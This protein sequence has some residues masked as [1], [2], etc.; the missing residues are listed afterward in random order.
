M[1]DTR[2]HSKSLFIVDGKGHGIESFNVVKN[3]DGTFQFGDRAF[4]SLNALPGVQERKQTYVYVAPVE[5]R[6]M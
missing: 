3:Q 2:L 6:T 1:K 5:L 4:P